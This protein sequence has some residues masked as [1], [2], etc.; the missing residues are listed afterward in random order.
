MS[1]GVLQNDVVLERHD[2]LHRAMQRSREL[3]A[4]LDAWVEVATS[5]GVVLAVAGPCETGG[6]WHMAKAR[7]KNMAIQSGTPLPDASIATLCRSCGRLGTV[8]K[9]TSARIVRYYCE[10]HADGAT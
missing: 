1:Y 7:R 9:Q 6:G 10:V 4:E 5:A 8:R 3:A 2:D